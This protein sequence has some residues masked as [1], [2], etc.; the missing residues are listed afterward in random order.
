VI[1]ADLF[2][3][4]VA[5][6]GAGIFAPERPRADLRYVGLRCACGGERF[7]VAGWPRVASGSGGL[8][9]RT[10]R[11]IWREA[12]E[13]M[14]RGESSE[15]P[16]WLPV[17]VACEACGREAMLLDGTQL[18]GRLPESERDHPREGCRCRA[19][20]RGVFQL[21]VGLAGVGREGTDGDDDS[22]HLGT[23]RSAEV[24]VRCVSCHRQARIAWSAPPPS[25]RQIH[26]DRLYGRS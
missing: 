18:A 7:G 13:P 6:T 12:R 21:E 15:S 19:C 23:P 17:R 24:V 26:L 16:F 9:L 3:P 5:D 8:I 25:D 1:S 22:P 10:L 20:R 14:E 2:A 11:R 4:F